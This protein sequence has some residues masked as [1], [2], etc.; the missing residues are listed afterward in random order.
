[1]HRMTSMPSSFAT[2]N[3]Y[4][5]KSI[6]AL[7]LYFTTGNEECGKKYSERSQLI[8]KD[9]RFWNGTEFFENFKCYMHFNVLSLTYQKTVL[10]LQLSFNRC[11]IVLFRD[12]LRYGPPVVHGKV[13]FKCAEW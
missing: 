6:T 1:M 2:A 8:G 4:F 10:V 7:L 3:R 13:L 5:S 11:N 9:F 12:K